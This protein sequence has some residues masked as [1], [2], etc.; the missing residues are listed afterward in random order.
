MKI[1]KRQLRQI[2]NEEK[3]KIL[4]E[5]QMIPDAEVME[6][7]KEGLIMIGLN[8]IVNEGD[9]ILESEVVQFVMDTSTMDQDRVY[10]A[11]EKLA[12]QNNLM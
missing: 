8:R 3:A 1:T 7:L 11:I 4:N 12:T 6:M 10:E 9:N 5:Q 2:I